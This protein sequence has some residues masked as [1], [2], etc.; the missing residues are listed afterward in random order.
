MTSISHFSDVTVKAFMGLRIDR[1]GKQ[2][3][4]SWHEGAKN[5]LTRLD[6]AFSDLSEPSDLLEIAGRIK[7][8]T[9]ALQVIDALLK[10]D[11]LVWDVI[12]PKAAFA[13]AEMRG[14]ESSE[15]LTLS[16]Q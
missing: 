10:A 4:A 1:N 7:F 6:L 15:L 5:K 3:L 14:M 8:I 12:I 11:T 16:S 2:K 13:D 9:Q